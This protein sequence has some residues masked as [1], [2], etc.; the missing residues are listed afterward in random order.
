VTVTVEVRVLKDGGFPVLWE[1]SGIYVPLP[2]EAGE[3]L[4][5]FVRPKTVADM[6]LAGQFT[7]IEESEL[8]VVPT[9]EEME[10]ARDRV[11]GDG[12]S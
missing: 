12:L 7:K 6:H 11:Y 8:R 4:L 10:A 9:V 2:G 5:G 3:G 1:G